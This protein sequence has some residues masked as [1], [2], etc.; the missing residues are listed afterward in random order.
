MH[1]SSDASDSSS[2]PVCVMASAACTITST[3]DLRP[4][5]FV[6]LIVIKE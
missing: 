1:Q 5:T 6:L 2:L 3:D 4:P